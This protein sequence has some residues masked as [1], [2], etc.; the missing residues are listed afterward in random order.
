MGGLFEVSVICGTNAA[1]LHIVRV[2]DNMFR[3]EPSTCVQE[4]N[5][6]LDATGILL[7]VLKNWLLVDSIGKR[8]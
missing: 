2:S 5:R 3:L 4:S 6:F 1:T 7:S 8:L